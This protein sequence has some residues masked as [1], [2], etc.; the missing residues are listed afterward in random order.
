MNDRLQSEKAASYQ[1]KVQGA[2]NPEY[3]D[4]LGGL[5]ISVYYDEGSPYTVLAGEVQDQAALMGVLDSLYNMRFPFL[6]IAFQPMK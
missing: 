2:I 5:N 1:I 4:Y 6:E 3:T